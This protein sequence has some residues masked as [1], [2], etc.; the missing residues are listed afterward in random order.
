MK[1]AL[2]IAIGLLIITFQSSLADNIALWGVKPDIIFI[3]VYAIGL[4]YNEEKAMLMGAGFG[5]AADIFSGGLLGLNLLS[6]AATGFAAGAL[7]KR[8][9]NMRLRLQILVIFFVTMLEVM[10][11]IILLSVF[12]KNIMFSVGI[13][14][15]FLQALYNSLFTFLFLWPLIKRLKRERE[16]LLSAKESI[17]IR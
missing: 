10:L 17:L 11:Q 7:G 12:S 14:I 3:F 13:K 6:K 5:L 4:I 2:L 1:R 9:L 16:W 8:I 15:I